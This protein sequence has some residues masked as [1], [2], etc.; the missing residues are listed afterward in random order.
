ML[1][2]LTRNE[3]EKLLAIVRTAF[4]RG[5]KSATVEPI[6][7]AERTGALPLS[8]A[9]QRLWFLAQLEGLSRV[10]HISGGLR[11]S[12][13]L[14]RAALRRA[15]NRIVERHEA[16][17]TTFQLVDGEPVQRIA[18]IEASNF[19]LI[20][21]DLRRHAEAERE[22]ARIVREEASAEFDLERGPL[23]RGR[24][25]RLEDEE[26]E[27][28]HALLLTMHHVV[29]DGW[30]MGV[31]GEE[32]SAL[33]GAY[34]MGQP[35]RLPELGIQYADY[36]VWQRRMDG[37]LLR[38]QAE[39]WKAALAGAPTVLELPAD[40]PRPARQNY[41]GG[42]VE[43]VLD[44]ELTAGLKA[45][46]QRRG[47]T[48][49][50]TLLAG[51][52]AVL[53][54]LSGQT[55]VV[56]GTPT[57]N[58]GHVQLE[59]L[60]GFFVN[61]L[62][63]RVDLGGWPTGEE[64]LEQVKGQT[65]GAQANQDIPFE[66]V[67]EMV[68]PVRSTAHSPLFQAMFGWEGTPPAGLALSGL[69][70]MPLRDEALNSDAGDA[71]A[72]G[73]KF[74]LTLGLR[75]QGGKIVG[76]FTY[77]TALY[78]RPTM[79]RHAEYLRNLL[80]GLVEDT[81]A[82]V[83][84][85]PMLSEA[86]REQ[87][88]YWWNRTEVEY[89][90]ER[91]I[92][93]LFEEQVAGRPGATAVEY[94]GATLTYGELNRQANRLAHYL[95]GLGVKPDERVA[96][97]LERGMEMMVG[98]LGV[99]KS[100]GAYVPLDPEYPPERLRF[101]LEDSAPKALLTQRHLRRLF[102]D[103]QL[104]IPVME[105]EQEKHWELPETNPDRM[106]G[107]TARHPAYVIYTSGS[108]GAPK[109][110]VVE[111]QSVGNLL[112]W[113]QR[114]YPLSAEGAVLQN[115]PF[116]FDASVTGF[117]WPLVTGA[118]VVM[119]RPEGHKDAAYLC[120]TIRNHGVTAIGFPISMLPVFA[121]QIDSP[122]C[123]TLAHVMCGGEALPGWVAR[124]FQER[125]PHV[126]LHNL[127][128]PTEATVASTA[129]TG[130]ANSVDAE[131]NIIPIGRPI[132][133][134]RIY[135]LDGAGE[136]VPVGVT[137]E[138]YIG[139]AGVA[140]GY[141]NRPELTAER[142]VADPFAQEPGARIY[143]TGDLGRWRAD[144]TIEFLGRNDFQV[145]I[146]GFRIELGEIEARLREHAGV[147]EAVVMARED[148]PGDK[149]LVAYYTASQ[150]SE[151]VSVEGLRAHL[152]TKLPEY[153]V[154]S[155]WVQLDALPLTPNGKL[156]R[157][158]LPPPPAHCYAGRRY[159]EPQGE[160]E[161]QIAQIWGEILKRDRVGRHD[162]FFELGGHSLL[163]VRMTSRLQQVSGRKVEIRQ[164]FAHPV[165]RDLAGALGEAARAEQEVIPRVDRSGALP[166]S[167][168][169]QRLWFRS[170]LDGLSRVYHMSGGF[171]LVGLLD[172]AALRRALN[173]I[174]ERHEALRTT[175][176][177]VDGDP[178]QRIAGIEESN[179]ALIDQDLRGHAQADQELERIMREEANA[180]F[181]LERGPLIRGRLIRLE[182]EGEEERHA[183][184]LTM[185]HILSDGWSM[186]V[187]GG[188]LSALYGAYREGKVDPLP[189]LGIQYG[190]YA[191]WQRQ[192][193]EGELLKRQAEYWKGA[194]TGAPALL[195][196]PADHPRPARQ[197]YAGAIVELV[198]DEALTA[199]LKGLS[200]RRGVTLYMTLLA[201]WAAV[202][203]RL[204]GQTDVVI[205]TP[206]ANRGHVQLEGLIGFF[207]N[208]LAVRV[209]LGGS[210]T[211]EEL[212][213]RVK[214]Q[215][216]GA[217]ANQDM[218]FEQV[219]E[220]VQP[221]RSTAHSPLFQALFAWQNTSRARLAFAGVQVM[222]LPG[223]A[224]AAAKFDL[225]LGLREQ[226]G[227]IVGGLTYATALFERDTMER[228]VEYLRNLLQGLV[229]DANAAVEQLPMLPPVR[230]GDHIK[231]NE[232]FISDLHGQP[233]IG[234][235][236]NV[237]RHDRSA[238]LLK[239]AAETIAC[240]VPLRLSDFASQDT[241][242]RSGFIDALGN[243]FV[244]HGYVL[245]AAGPP[246]E[247]IQSYYEAAAKLLCGMPEEALRKFEFV[248]QGIERGY[249]SS[250]SGAPKPVTIS[251]EAA[252]QYVAAAGLGFF[253]GSHNGAPTV[254]VS[255]TDGEVH[256]SLPTAT[257]EVNGSGGEA[258]VEHEG[259]SLRFRCID[260]RRVYQVFA[261]D[262]KHGWITGR[263]HNI[264]P[265]GM[266]DFAN[267]SASVYRAQEAVCL[268]VLEA[269]AQFLD[270]RNGVIRN[271]VADGSGQCIAE[272]S[273]RVYRYPG[274]KRNDAW[275]GDPLLVRVGE[276][277][278]ISLLTVLA[279]AS[280]PGLQV[281]T[282]DGAWVSVRAPENG[283]V[284]LAGEIL[285]EMTKGLRSGTGR[286][287][288]IYAPLHRVVGSPE[289][290]SE[291]RYTAPF[292]FNPDLRQRIPSLAD[293]GAVKIRGIELNPGLRL[294]HSHMRASTQFAHLTFEEFAAE[295]ERLGERLSE[296]LAKN[297][298][299]HAV[300]N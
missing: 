82:T 14:D 196:L 139:G 289:T 118:R 68:Q 194:L 226:A 21:Q 27:E 48:L 60:I 286:P 297:P 273:L 37:E 215:V 136:P 210:P 238:G 103:E 122:E 8:F 79:E 133:N 65:L 89:P 272:H 222:P 113:T 34:R 64:L 6:P 207:V 165:L 290:M 242:S 70:V 259:R 157:K 146:R 88:L 145:K 172:R 94:E 193:M 128:G 147:R 52:A 225:T 62:A 220:M 202:L 294:L 110:V 47:M 186:G 234:P 109:G 287:L 151:E 255:G 283:L 126:R 203:S 15:L 71:E 256:V 219:L 127:Y 284:V 227:K 36:A 97:C 54:R 261:P 99:L 115:A 267:L 29:S 230:K 95:R 182:D 209:D 4:P 187:M 51:W 252:P 174:V 40:H 112:N 176:Q 140:R 84:Q 192:R 138:L 197:N 266:G 262:D 245:L 108:S 130:S 156:D 253:F 31:M 85:L 183:L 291:D 279:K 229:G 211:G 281:Q 43:L 13:A 50:M 163:A 100:G 188:E 217:Q 98:L 248:K 246:Q 76:G 177:L 107:F 232:K 150:A 114:T 137:G 205:G 158:A 265:A 26:D 191:V 154:P 274:M 260:S 125:L 91:C 282:R 152:L 171:R 235:G 61:M 249:V 78:E 175:F 1:E 44:E 224:Y 9:Q 134:T 292:F 10:Y 216:V 129:W 120:R 276:H 285:S 16:L 236:W 80:Q 144:G 57:A 106:A 24:L 87:V 12:G 11:L 159:E 185:H 161:S 299:I 121:E 117:F 250:P 166:L 268:T 263:R 241:T 213:E 142:F 184:L 41:A 201:G 75:E 17:R 59:L 42:M 149:R 111:H 264:Y 132:A 66:Q 74:D 298:Q 258:R 67:V 269:L 131:L 96:L 63:V 38:G 72:L 20:E 73:A 23:I 77:A 25:I 218:P 49:Y 288:R 83:E 195:E 277:R 278:D 92:H 180:Q 212:L 164:L 28:R 233:I 160:L 93:E 69:R 280:L 293:G 208:N 32:L 148:E 198:L 53:C 204:S 22:L 119:A 270:D 39:Y 178:V 169:Q 231:I 5:R 143:K 19:A 173:R 214:G 244:E 105:L 104:T 18:G 179:F 33:Y 189:E 167:F 116:G 247:E 271:L 58:R 181:D 102:A 223:E 56:I 2:N 81:S 141:L 190:D 228:H 200:Q 35:D 295:F 55:E 90:R 243:A 170:Q 30:S 275:L 254:T 300:V 199:G 3:R 221:V 162:N 124:Q 123:T 239:D 206:A 46:S 257:H 153:M 101:M 135:I 240:Q 45:L 168:A 237:S 251:L 7:R 86:E 155:G 296:V